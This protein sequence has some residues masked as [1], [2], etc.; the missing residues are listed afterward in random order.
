MPLKRVIVKVWTPVAVGAWGLLLSVGVAAQEAPSTAGKEPPAVGNQ[1]D[2]LTP[3]GG[4]APRGTQA[5]APSL[6]ALMKQ[7][8]RNG[9]GKVAK[10]EATG[11]FQQRFASW[12]TDGDGFATREEI[13][14]YRTSMGID[15][16]GQRTGGAGASRPA[17]GAGNGP[18]REATAVILKGPE[19]WRLETFPVPPGFAPGVK[20]KGSEEVR[21]SPGMYQPDSPQYFTYIVAM[22]TEG[23]APFGGAELKDFLEQYFRGLLTGRAQRQGKTID[24]AE[25]QA[26]ILPSVEGA[27]AAPL[28]ADLSIVDAFTDGRKTTLHVDAYVHP[29]PAV[30]KTCLILLISASPRESD[31]WKNLREVGRAAEVNLP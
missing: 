7:L 3:N 18:R 20:L 27:A 12:D 14:A 9:D 2:G 28:R 25:I 10:A 4:T 8:D 15:D 31:T 21:F 13:R 1:Q 22:T 24:P 11:A 16:A 26:T 19:E 23:T 30:E 5:Q 17:G 29:R 6:D